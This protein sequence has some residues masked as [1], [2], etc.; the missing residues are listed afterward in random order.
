MMPCAF[1]ARVN[2]EVSSVVSDDRV[3]VDN[4]GFHVQ[5]CGCTCS[6]VVRRIRGELW[7]SLDIG[8]CHD[9]HSEQTI[10]W[11]IG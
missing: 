8:C 5:I 6:V 9:S 2:N 10:E 4:G 1:T 7:N 3:V 11:S